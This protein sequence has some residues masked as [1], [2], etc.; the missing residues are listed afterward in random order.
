[1]NSLPFED[2]VLDGLDPSLTLNETSEIDTALLSD[3]DAA[4]QAS[5]L[6]SWRFFPNCKTLLSAHLRRP[7]WLVKGQEAGLLGGTFFDSPKRSPRPLLLSVFSSID[8]HPF[9]LVDHHCDMLQLINTEDSDFPGL[10]D[11]PFAGNASPDPNSRGS[12]LF[13]GY[14]G[15]S[16]PSTSSLFQLPAP[17]QTSFQTLSPINPN[18]NSTP[19]DVK[20]EAAAATVNQPPTQ[21]PSG[22]GTAQSFVPAPQAQFSPQPLMGFPSQTGIPG[23]ESENRGPVL[24]GVGLAE[25]TK[26]LRRRLF[27]SSLGAEI[28]KG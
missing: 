21:M 27:V 25:V 7:G 19:M 5:I 20:E 2:P 15:A 6:G 17:S 24:L 4:G 22:R 8:G 10:F 28:R 3:I 13:G 1:M 12:S 23:E 14:L 16:N 9:S 26:S 18:V 11:A